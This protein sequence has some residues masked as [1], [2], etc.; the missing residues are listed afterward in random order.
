MTCAEYG[1]L[2]TGEQLQTLST[3]LSEHRLEPGDTGNILGVTS[4]VDGFCGTGFPGSA[5]TNLEEPIEDAVDWES[6]SW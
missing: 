3:L 2:S 1:A 5:T 4:A 6:S